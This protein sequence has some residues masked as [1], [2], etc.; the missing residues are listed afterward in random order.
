MAS[1]KIQLLFYSGRQ[2]VPEF[3]KNYHYTHQK[4][5]YRLIEEVPS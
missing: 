2:V 1:K 3:M 5:K 4:S